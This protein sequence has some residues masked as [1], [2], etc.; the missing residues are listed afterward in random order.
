M[1]MMLRDFL[2]YLDNNN[3]T[4]SPLVN[5]VMASQLM[6]L[7]F[8]ICQETILWVHVRNS[9]S[10]RSSGNAGGAHMARRMAS[11]CGLHML[12]SSCLLFWPLFDTSDWSW[13]LNALVPAV[14]MTRFVYKVKGF[15]VYT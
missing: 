3:N 13:R 1:V 12:L 14:M 10:H 4:I 2:P 5:N 9:S 6:V 11:R 15:V 7:Y 8:K